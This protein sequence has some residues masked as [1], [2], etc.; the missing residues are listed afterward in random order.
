MP[1]LIIEARV[2]S[3][4]VYP[5]ML[6]SLGEDMFRTLERIESN[7]II[8]PWLDSSN[9]FEKFNEC[10]VR[11]P[12]LLVNLIFKLTDQIIHFKTT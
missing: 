8:Q 4:E 9:Y 6:M 2:T 1:S 11:S 12:F 7:L 10:R 5:S 3:Y